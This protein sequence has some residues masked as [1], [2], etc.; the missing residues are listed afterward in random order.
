MHM[1][2]CH[3]K[4]FQVEGIW[5]PHFKQSYIVQYT[6]HLEHAALQSCTVT[7]LH[8]H[9]HT[10]IHTHTHTMTAAVMAESQLRTYVRMHTIIT[11]G[12]GGS[13]VYPGLRASTT[14]WEMDWCE[15]ET[16]QDGVRV[17]VVFLKPYI[18]PDQSQWPLHAN[19][20][21]Y[22]VSFKS[23]GHSMHVT[24]WKIVHGGRAHQNSTAWYGHVR[25]YIYLHT[26]TY[27]Y[28]GIYI[29]LHHISSM[30]FCMTLY[31]YA[32]H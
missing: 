13:Q 18:A 14:R 23:S 1:R 2:W 6:S 12:G 10:H 15:E 17:Q 19:S 21:L 5:F 8:T 22:I 9:T 3:L 29:T 7:R 25:K 4:D 30:T 32:M 16:K 28:M 24:L 27:V 20:G 31:I 11:Q 26:C